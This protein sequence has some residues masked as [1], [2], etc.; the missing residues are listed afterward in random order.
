MMDGERTCKLL[1]YKLT[2]LRYMTCVSEI[3]QFN[4]I[5][6]SCRNKVKVKMSLCL[7]S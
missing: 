4:R 3:V 5:V 2:A 6:Q 7:K 1:S